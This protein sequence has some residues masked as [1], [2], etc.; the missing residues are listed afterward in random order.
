M[1]FPYLH[2][3]QKE[4]LALR[5]LGPTLAREGQVQPVIE[6]VRHVLASLRQTLQTCESAGLP[7]WL[8]VNPMSQDFDD[9]APSVALDWGRHLLASLGPR[10]ALRPT[11]LLHRRMTPELVR[12]FAQSF[13]GQAVGVVI[14]PGA[15]PI[16]PM[17]ELLRAAQLERVFFKNEPPS[18]ATLGMIGPARCIW[19]ENRPVSMPTELRRGSTD[20][21]VGR[22]FFSDSLAHF[23]TAGGPGF[24]DHTSLP[25]RPSA[26]GPSG[27]DHFH[28]SYCQRHGAE[29]GTMRIEYFLA[30]RTNDPPA[31]GEQEPVEAEP[32]FFGALRK[33]RLAVEREDDC[34]GPTLGLQR[35]LACRCEPPA[36]SP[37]LMRQWQLMHHLELVSGVLSGRYPLRG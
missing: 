36:P 18:H 6:P 32:R 12:L 20:P 22:Q 3:M 30:D 9:V 25:S 14:V 23:L 37:A 28:L 27:A 7:T 33:L 8:V 17:L 21:R 1:Y 2:G 31:E 29:A 16:E 10:R 35:F 26:S 5:Q 4:I 11:L 15:L 24:S 34:F 19:V 13:A